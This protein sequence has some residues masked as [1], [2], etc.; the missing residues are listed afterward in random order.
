[1]CT[2]TSI[3]TPPATTSTSTTT[4]DAVHSNDI[5]YLTG[6]S[7]FIGK[8]LIEEIDAN[9]SISKVYCPVRE[10]KGVSGEERFKTLFQDSKKA[11]FID[12]SDALPEDVTLV[13]L[14]AYDVRFFSPVENILKQNVA[15]MRK[16]IDQCNLDK[17]RGICIVSTAYVQPPEPYKC[18]DQN[19]IPF[20]L[21]KH[22]SAGKLYNDLTEGRTTW[23][24]V[25]EKYDREL[26][27]HHKTNCYA[28]SKV[29]MENAMHEFYPNHPICIV[30]PSI[31]APSR[32]GRHGFGTRA[33]FPLFVELARHPVMRAPRCEGKLN[34][35]FVDDVAKDIIRG[36]S[37][38]AGPV[39]LDSKGRPFHP[40]YMSTS[41]SDLTSMDFLCKLPMVKR[42]R[43]KNKPVRDVIRKME[44]LSIR[45][46]KG[47]KQSKLIKIM[48]MNYD[49]IMRESFD[50]SATHPPNTEEICD[51][52][53][54]YY[55]KREIEE[56]TEKEERKRQK[57][58]DKLEKK[59]KKNSSSSSPADA[60]TT[61][62][63]EV[64]WNKERDCMYPY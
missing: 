64:K 53:R 36:A 5:V 35:V 60:T 20:F 27:R 9:D 10:K 57:K 49:M 19:R 14:N 59:S 29:I 28:S 41:T 52:C 25:I 62:T 4:T 8:V 7:G 23:K 30:R 34:L 40:I 17:V 2:E 16:I 15:T 51:V 46:V 12:P 39:Q 31:V 54:V 32:D 18:P 44:Q 38:F 11:A 55:D 13:I 58:L 42:F 3:D 21:E 22:F 47:K 56:K 6:A 48:Y 26:T 45:A 1:M 43:V 37:E 24:E 50:F 33:G 61:V 63:V